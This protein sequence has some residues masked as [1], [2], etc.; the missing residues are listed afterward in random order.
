MTYTPEVPDSFNV[1]QESGSAQI[2][3][4]VP[5]APASSSRVPQ[6]PQPTSFSST[7]PS[8][9]QN[10]VPR[11]IPIG[12][13]MSPSPIPSSCANC[14]VA[15][16]G[17]VLNNQNGQLPPQK[18]ENGGFNVLHASSGIISGSAPGPM[19]YGMANIQPPMHPIP[20]PVLG[21]FA[22]NQPTWQGAPNGP[23]GPAPI[24]QR[25]I[26][27]VPVPVNAM[28]ANFVG[29]NMSF[30]Q[31]PPLV[32]I[33]GPNPQPVPNIVAPIP[34]ASLELGR[35]GQPVISY[36]SQPPPFHHHP[37]S[38]FQG[39]APPLVPVRASILTPRNQQKPP[40]RPTEDD[41][42]TQLEFI[43]IDPQRDTNLA[44][45]KMNPKLM[46]DLY[47]EMDRLAR[48]ISSETIPFETTL[49]LIR[50]VLQKQG[51]SNPLDWRL[52]IRTHSCKYPS[53]PCQS[54]R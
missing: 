34:N 46:H 20:L 22:G 21:P 4:Q 23:Q 32:R 5:E 12:P 40:P 50:Q 14:Q 18:P 9:G 29:P 44:S 45:S 27:N 10:L 33:P 1:M 25:P 49:N 15:R 24:Y 51:F 42:A 52:S 13:T 31:G 35:P 39:A 17:A 2:A 28:Q 19:H 48:Q 36:A 38:S 47:E 54:D 53:L 26:P 7:T 8:M 3:A 16:N 30:N 6:G 37:P 43:S 41:L 11:S